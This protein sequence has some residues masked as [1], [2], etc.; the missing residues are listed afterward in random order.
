[1][2]LKYHKLH[3]VEIDGSLIAIG[4]H[5]RTSKRR[6]VA[7]FRALLRKCS[8]EGEMN[9]ESLSRYSLQ[10]SLVF[11]MGT[12]RYKSRNLAVHKIFAQYVADLSVG[13]L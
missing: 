5:V 11:E 6:V 12:P 13:N 3:S 7:Y 2:Y 8:G 1:M 9:Y 10:A 4:V